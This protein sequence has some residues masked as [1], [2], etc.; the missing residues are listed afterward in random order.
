MSSGKTRLP[1]DKRSD[2]EKREDYIRERAAVR[3][4]SVEEYKAMLEKRP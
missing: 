4:I 2:E 1:R 3:G